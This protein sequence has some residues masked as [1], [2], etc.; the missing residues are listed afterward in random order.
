M[1]AGYRPIVADN[2]STDGSAGGRPRAAAP[3]W[4]ACRSPG[5]GAAVHAGVLAADPVDGVVCVHGRRRLV[6]P[7]AA[8]PAWPIRSGPA[9][10]DWCSAGA[11]RPRGGR[12]RCT[13]GSA[14]PLLARRL[15]RTTGLDVHDLGPMRA[16][17]RADLLA[18]GLRDRRFGYPLEM[19]IAAGRAGWRV[20]EVDVD[21][22][23]AGGRDPVEGDRHR[24]RHRPRRPRHERGA[25]PVSDVPAHA[26]GA[27]QGAGAGPGQ[28]PALPAVHP[29]QAARVAAAALADTL[30]TVTAAPAGTPGPGRRRRPPGPAGLDER[31]PAGRPAGRAAG[32]RVRR[33]PHGR[34]RP[35]C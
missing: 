31:R 3:R 21:Y 4:S 18:L 12:G 6:R 20:A 26:A 15:R 17:R 2:G 32:P 8:A 27:G 13:P 10:R 25:G 14:T 34:A 9:R 33:H 29:E 1:P 23:P 30:D 35:A 7:G 22:A 16:A 5:F 19:L 11:A 28:D 24:A